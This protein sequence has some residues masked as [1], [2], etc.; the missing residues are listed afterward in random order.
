MSTL[1]SRYLICFLTALT[2]SSPLLA[3]N[4]PSGRSPTVETSPD[5]A[6]V[7]SLV[8]QLCNL[9]EEEPQ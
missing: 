7:R 1:K 5:E 4:K 9:R 6:S 8:D 3:Q 2:V